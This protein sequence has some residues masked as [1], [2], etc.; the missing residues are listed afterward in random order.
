WPGSGDRWVEGSGPE[1]ARAG[2]SGGGDGFD[3]GEQVAGGAG[4]GDGCGG[5]LERGER[6]DGRLDVAA[7]DVDR[8]GD[9]VG[10]PDELAGDLELAIADGAAEQRAEVGR[11]GGQGPDH[12]QVVD[13][14]GDV[15]AGGLAE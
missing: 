9:A 3:V 4:E 13:A 14:L 2:W 10:A 7:G 5:A 1:R 12:G 15:V 8:L 6:G 11:A